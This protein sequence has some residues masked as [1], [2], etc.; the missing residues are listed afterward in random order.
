V[1]EENSLVLPIEFYFGNT[2]ANVRYA[3]LA[4][5]NIGLYRFE[6]IVPPMADDD[7]APLT[8]KLGGADGGQALYTAVR[9]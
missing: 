6:V 2:L 5:G 7:A 8:F 4:P 3:G 9:N 1:Q